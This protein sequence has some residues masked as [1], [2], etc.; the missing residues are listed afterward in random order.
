MQRSVLQHPTLF[1]HD[2]HRI[3]RNFVDDHDFAVDEA[4]F[5]LHVDKDE[6]LIT[7][8]GFDDTAHL[9]GEILGL[10][11]VLLAK[12]AEGNDGVVVDKGITTFVVLDGYLDEVVE[13]TRAVTDVVLVTPLEAAPRPGAADELE[14]ALAADILTQ[15]LGATDFHTGLLE[16]E[17]HQMSWDAGSVEALEEMVSHGEG[18]SAF[19]FNLTDDGVGTW[20]DDP[21]RASDVV[22]EDEEDI[23]IRQGVQVL[24][25]AGIDLFI[26]VHRFTHW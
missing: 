1:V 20:I 6:A 17:T 4:D 10:L 14:A 26:S 13:R 11:K 25:L 19:A 24:G 2:S 21:V 16:V 5:D 9:A 23:V 12:E 22:L 15:G 8:V 3:R 18:L 7:E